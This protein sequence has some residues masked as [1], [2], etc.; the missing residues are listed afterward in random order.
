MKVLTDEG[1]F[2]SN[3]DLD[4]GHAIDWRIN[5]GVDVISISIGSDESFTDETCPDY[6]DDEINDAYNKSYGN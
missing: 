3:W 5:Q 1:G 4:V 2:T 6:V